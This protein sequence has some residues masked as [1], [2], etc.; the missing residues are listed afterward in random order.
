MLDSIEHI[1]VYYNST[2]KY[3]NAGVHL[4]SAKI[5]FYCTN[6]TQQMSSLW[7]NGNSS[8]GAVHE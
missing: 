8:V 6:R 3:W 2:P 5:K 7:V 4:E 1:I